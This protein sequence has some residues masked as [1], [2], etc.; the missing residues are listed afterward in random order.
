[1][2]QHKQQ[3]HTPRSP[4]SHGTQSPYH[5]GQPLPNFSIASQIGANQSSRANGAPPVYRAANI[6]APR[7]GVARISSP[8]VYRRS[9]QVGVTQAK[10]AAGRPPVYR[11]GN[12]PAQPHS[13]SRVLPP[14]VYSP[15]RQTG[16]SQAKAA[17][18]APSVYRP[19]NALPRVQNL[20]RTSA[21]PVY[22]LL[23]GAPAGQAKLIAKAPAVYRPDNRVPVLRTANDL[24]R[25]ANRAGLPTRPQSSS[26]TPATCQSPAMQMKAAS[27]GTKGQQLHTN[28]AVNVVQRLVYLLSQD[29][30][31][32]GT[33][34]NL[35]QLEQGFVDPTRSLRPV[36][37]PS[38]PFAT[39]ERN[40]SLHIIVHGGGGT[41]EGMDSPQE[42]AE[43][44][45]SRGLDP[46]KHRGTIRLISC[47]SGTQVFD[48]GSSFVEQFAAALRKKGFT[49]P[50]I[51]FDGL[52]RAASGGQIM[53]IAPSQA[54]EFFKLSRMGDL[55]KNEFAELQQIKPS[56]T[57]S[58][59]EV[60]I[61]LD[62]VNDTKEKITKVN[63]KMEALWV[64]Q[65]IGKNTVHIPEVKEYMGDMPLAS[66]WE[67]KQADQEWEEWQTR[68]MRAFGMLGNNESIRPRTDHSSEY[69]S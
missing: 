33:Y 13:A 56:A 34:R 10:L 12:A 61:F 68:K 63:K 62:L 24:T 54:A 37:D 38:S 55:L 23:Q 46:D 67:R 15:A 1:M 43:F 69:I 49:N 5:A 41:V 28:T 27:S 42:F 6:S 4:L 39:L 45:I 35:T 48:D 51:G 58:Q 25:G 14:T 18:G 66:L 20:S 53:V 65:A 32:K 47:F 8:P 57:A 30:L 31:N 19:N 2:P 26:A 59:E 50:V 52:V 7:Q 44:L 9:M 60:D 16:V 36:P 22:H 11:P 21:P 17:H 40:E 29:V 3:L 64:P